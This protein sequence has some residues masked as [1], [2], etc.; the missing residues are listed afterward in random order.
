MNKRDKSIKKNALLNTVKQ[1]SAVIFPFITFTYCSHILG[2]ENMGQFSLVQTIVSYCAYLATF[3][4]NEYAIRETSPIRY[5]RKAFNDI[6]SQIFS[7]TCIMTVLSYAVLFI[8]TVFWRDSNTYSCILLIYS[9]TILFTTIGVDWV[10]TVY[11]DFAYL[12]V[13]Y[14]AIQVFCLFVMFLTVR[15][16]NDLVRYVIIVTIATSG[17]NLLNIF[18]IRK[19]VKIQ[20]TFKMNFLI[21]IK[22][23]FVFFINNLSVLLYLNSDIILLRYFTNDFTVGIYTI[24]T[25]IYTIIKSLINA[26]TMVLVPRVTY[27]IEN[28]QKEI[29]S[30]V[31]ST[32]LNKLCFILFPISVGLFFESKNIILLVAGEEYIGGGTVLAIYSI[33]I[34]FAVFSCF[35]SYVVL[36]P[37]RKEK[38]FLVST[39]VAATVNIVGNFLLIPVISLNGAAITTLMS[40]FIVFVLTLYKSKKIMYITINIVD[41]SKEL[42]GVFLISVICFS[43]KEIIGNSINELIIA[44]VTSMIAYIILE[45]V[46]KNS[47]VEDAKMLISRKF[48]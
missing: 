17:G 43:C 39:L 6:A 13:R 10:N 4:V 41:L 25:K 12:A 33:A 44:T 48:K 32:M 14:I 15:N 11:E 5:N 16:S 37:N 42:G 18:Y 31:C 8:I 1:G 24:A 47:I 35:Y 3:G 27:Y 36:I 26:I 30:K 7:I 40:E 28:D 46:L 38:Y 21:H 19:K 9:L 2:A 29:A 34:I 20:F 45:L 23:M 22:R